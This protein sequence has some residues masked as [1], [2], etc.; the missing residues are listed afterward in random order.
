MTS[1]LSL[2]ASFIAVKFYG[3]T[4]NPKIA[5][6]FDPYTLKFYEDVVT[7]LP[8]KLSWNHKALRS[9]SWRNF[10]VWWE[11][12]LL[13]GD[14]MHIISRKYYVET[15]LQKALE[16]GFEQIVIMGAGFD[17]NGALFAS[18]DVPVFEI[19]TPNM[20]NH[21]RKMLHASGYDLDK[22]FLCAIDPSNQNIEEVLIQS[23]A[24]DLDKKT[25]FLAEGFFDYLSLESVKSILENITS[26]SNDF[27]LVSTFFDLGELNFLHRFMFT[28]GVAMVGETL[29]LPL[30]K[31]EFIE[32]LT[33]F[34]ISTSHQISY[35][36][37]EEELI[38]KMNIDLPVLH[39]FYILE[40][41]YNQ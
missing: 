21:K 20:I 34:D 35:K 26:F 36:D 13:P 12:L 6:F 30:N 40:S 4:L 18:K 2:T 11:E 38:T 41:E 3:L 22:L 5:V 25:I 31:K 9:K 27:K 7:Y 24:F 16:S 37:I 29:K 15:T 23:G 14:L 39:G 17:H 19:D 1:S 8:K 28:S 33:E 10:F 32:L